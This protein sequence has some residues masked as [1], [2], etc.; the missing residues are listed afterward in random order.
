MSNLSSADIRR[1]LVWSDKFPDKPGVYLM[2]PTKSMEAPRRVVVTEHGAVVPDSAQPGEGAT[3]L[4]VYGMSWLPVADT[5]LLADLA[6]LLEAAL[7]S[8]P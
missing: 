3:L 6:K 2:R 1:F 4:Q 7:A 5:S 8:K